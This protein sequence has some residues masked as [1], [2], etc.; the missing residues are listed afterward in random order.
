MH[1]TS[2]DTEEDMLSQ[3]I[4]RPSRNDWRHLI[5]SSITTV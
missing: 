2:V 4:I 3:V 1:V 5:V